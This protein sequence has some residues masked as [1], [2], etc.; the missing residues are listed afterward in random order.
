MCIGFLKT[1]ENIEKKV[2]NP[3][4]EIWLISLSGR[5]EKSPPRKFEIFKDC[6]NNRLYNIYHDRVMLESKLHEI[7]KKCL[8]IHKKST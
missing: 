5:N 7:K 1:C 4:I 2:L 6:D 3:I 8:D